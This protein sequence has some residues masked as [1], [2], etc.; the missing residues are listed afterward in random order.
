MIM[1]DM[2]MAQIIQLKW[3]LYS[4]FISLCILLLML[5]HSNLS[6]NS[7]ESFFV[8]VIDLDCVRACKQGKERN[9]PLV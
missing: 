7:N 5:N 8:F 1:Y 6:M 9:L 3:H 2:I 4:F